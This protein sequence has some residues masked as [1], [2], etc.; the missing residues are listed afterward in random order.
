MNIRRY[1]WRPFV[2]QAEAFVRS[3]LVADHPSILAGIRWCVDEIA[4]AEKRREHPRSYELDSFLWV[5]KCPFQERDKVIQV[6]DERSAGRF[7][8]VPGNVLYVRTRRG[9]RRTVSFV[10][11]ERP[12]D[13]RRQSALAFG[14]V[15]RASPS[16]EACDPDPSLRPT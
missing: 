9:A 2:L 10:Y 11:V 3:Q 12:S 1:V 15:R 4:R 5:R 13:R 14:Q 6:I 8:Y 7:I 16:P